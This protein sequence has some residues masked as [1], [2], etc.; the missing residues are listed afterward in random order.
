MNMRT[1]HKKGLIF[2][3]DGA[4]AVTVVVL[5]VINSVYY[6][7]VASKSSLSHLQSVNFAE[8]VITTYDYL[9][10]FDAIAIN[11]TKSQAWMNY[12]IMPSQLNIS[13]FLPPNYEMW[14]SV[15][16]LK[17]SIAGFPICSSGSYVNVNTASLERD[18]NA[19]IQI[20]TSNIG[21]F[22]GVLD[23]LVN[24]KQILRPLKP[25]V[26]TIIT[27][28]L[29]PFRKGVNVVGIRADGLCAY[30]MRVVG[31]EVY[32]GST[33][34]TMALNNLF[35]KDRFIGSGA[36]LVTVKKQTKLNPQ[37]SALEGTHIIRYKIWLKG[38][39]SL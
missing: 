12:Q 10:A 28:G 15:S 7:S 16:D 6:F 8:D 14:V 20:N 9:G 11:N 32:A 2:A 39:T 5:M 25:G 17:E 29:F 35:P 3:L 33:N 26:S 21:A 36:H 4:I 13:R 27:T 37:E 31:S 23:V 18:M 38:G 19:Y 1:H 22:G 24:G 30:W 34:E